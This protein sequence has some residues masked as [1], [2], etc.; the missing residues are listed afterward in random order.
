MRGRA[1][2]LARSG[3][4]TGGLDKGEERI[5]VVEAV[6]GVSSI[7]DLDHEQR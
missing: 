6:E 5:G 2:E 4:K 7:R 1:G 3:A